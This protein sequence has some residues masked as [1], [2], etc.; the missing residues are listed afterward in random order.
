MGTGSRCCVSIL[1]VVTLTTIVQSELRAAELTRVFPSFGCRFTLPG[2]DWRWDDS[3]S[4]NQGQ[5]VKGENGFATGFEMIFEAKNEKG[6]AVNLCRMTT[7]WF[8]A[9]D[10]RFVDGFESGF[11]KTSG[12][13][14][15][16]GRFTTFQGIP[17]YQLEA[18]AA[19]GRALTGTLL[20]ANG[21]AYQLLMMS[22]KGAVEQEKNFQAIM[23]GFAFLEPPI[24]HSWSYAIAKRTGEALVACLLA[25]ML[26]ILCRWLASRKLRNCAGEAA[27]TLYKKDMKGVSNA[28]FGIGVLHALLIA[29]GLAIE[30]NLLLVAPGLIIFLAI[31]AAIFVGL[32]VLARRE[33]PWVNHAIAILAWLLLALDFMVMSLT[34]PD[35]GRTDQGGV[36]I[37]IMALLLYYSLKNIQSLRRA[38]AAGLQV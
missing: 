3:V 28:L 11:Y 7:P 1:T 22:P 24:V 37:L 35:Y 17:C 31:S 2:D 30:K 27:L 36:G 15:R 32:G 21:Y 19:D 5:A 9:L 10:Q 8:V 33:T 14:K 26:L 18:T 12:L 13:K 6:F 25:G 38:R 20:L 23:N 16:G 4:R 34:G 29:L